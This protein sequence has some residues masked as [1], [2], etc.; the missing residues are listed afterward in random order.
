M[1]P[2]SLVK[3]LKGDL[4]WITVRAMEKDR[5]RRYNSPSDLAAD[6]ERHLRDLPVLASSPGRIY[7]LGK[8][9]RRHRLG[10]AASTIFVSLLV[11][12]S[13]TVTMQARRISRERDRAEKVLEDEST[14]DE[15][16]VRDLRE[17]LALPVSVLDPSVRAENCLVSSEVQTIGDLVTR[18]EGEMLKIKNFGKT[19]LR[20]I[21]KKLAD[22]GL[23][24]NMELPEGVLPP[25]AEPEDGAAPAQREESSW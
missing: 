2:S 21:K 18:A 1:E 19:S 10:V 16:R 9:V 23:G 3:R 24:F 4:D 17:K 5:A 6:I 7:R 20:E 12:Y 15:N 13:A 14:S 25:K 22:M 8:F 11:A